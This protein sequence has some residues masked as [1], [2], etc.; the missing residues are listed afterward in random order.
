MPGQGDASSPRQRLLDAVIAHFTVDGLADQSLRHIAAASGTSH[1]MLLYHFGSKDGLLLAVARAVEEQTRARFA[2]IGTEAGGDTDELV[3]RVWSYVADPSLADFERLFFAL[4]GRALQ[5]DASTLPLL[6]DDLE[7]WLDANVALSG[8]LGIPADVARVHAR[9]GLAVA[10]GLLLDLLA[11]G[12]RA[13]TDASL[14]AFA[15][16]YA[17]RWWEAQPVADG[18]SDRA[19]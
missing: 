5:G 3:R 12:D 16:R 19:S 11:T 14:E 10:R 15:R 6:R 7:H 4:Y 17:G 8:A 1:R 2:A 18:T 9:L 13:G